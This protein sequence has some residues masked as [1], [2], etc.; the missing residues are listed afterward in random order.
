MP[1]SSIRHRKPTHG[2]PVQPGICGATRCQPRFK[3]KFAFPLDGASAG[4][5]RDATRSPR[6]HSHSDDTQCSRKLRERPLKSVLTAPARDENFLG[7]FVIQPKPP[8]AIGQLPGLQYRQRS[9][10]V[11]TRLCS[12]CVSGTNRARRGGRTLLKTYPAPGCCGLEEGQLLCA[13]VQYNSSARWA[14]KTRQ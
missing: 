13:C 11:R 9:H 1:C 8:T 14:W 12:F 3:P 5:K 10:K 7:S 2:I 4:F 6:E